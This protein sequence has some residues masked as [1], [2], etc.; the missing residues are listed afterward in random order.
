MWA[1]DL[2]PSQCLQGQA[3]TLQSLR[4]LFQMSGTLAAAVL[5]TKAINDNL[6]VIIYNVS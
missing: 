6:G 4:P 3:P 2:T 5:S 1:S